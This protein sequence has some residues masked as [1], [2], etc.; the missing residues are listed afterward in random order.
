[1]SRVRAQPYADFVSI[2]DAVGD[3][4]T[5]IRLRCFRY[6]YVDEYVNQFVSA[7]NLLPALQQNGSLQDVTMDVNSQSPFFTEDGL[8]LVQFY[9]KRY[10]A[11]PEL[12]AQP[13]LDDEEEEDSE[14]TDRCL[15]PTL[16]CLAQQARRTA[17]TSMLI[18]ILALGDS[19][20]PLKVG[21]RLRADPAL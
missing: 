4:A 10:Q 14:K 13:L 6:G 18:G 15:F 17:P 16:F 2:C 9:Y 21:K 5:R 20:G 7:Q 19:I 3:N 12:V 8:R 11:I 1:M